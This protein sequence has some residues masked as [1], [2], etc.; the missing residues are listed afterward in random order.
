MIA[1]LEKLNL[2]QENPKE[3]LEVEE[4]QKESKKVL[5]QMKEIMN[6]HRHLRL[7]KIFK[8]K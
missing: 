6:D 2:N 3:D 7:S 4:H 1:K 8:E 5:L